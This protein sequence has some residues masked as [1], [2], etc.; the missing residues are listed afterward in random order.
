MCD[1]TLTLIYICMF[2][3]IYDLDAL[4]LLSFN[5]II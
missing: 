5:D 1:V 3:F 4:M 2:I